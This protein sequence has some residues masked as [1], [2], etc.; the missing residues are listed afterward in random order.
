MNRLKYFEET[1]AKCESSFAN[2]PKMFFFEMVI[3]QL[4]YLIDVE[5]GLTNDLSKLSQIKIGWIAIREMDGYEDE[6]LIQD[7]C[8]ISAEAE[9]MKIEKKVNNGKKQ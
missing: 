7:L 5:K 3:D 9:K 6:G 2:D 4:K 8:K 1:L